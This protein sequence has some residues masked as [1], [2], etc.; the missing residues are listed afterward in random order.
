MDFTFAY[1][2]TRVIGLEGIGLYGDF[3]LRAEGAYFLTGDGEGNDPLVRNPYFQ[4]VAQL[5]WNAP[6]RTM[7]ILQYLGMAPTLLD[8]RD[9]EDTEE[10]L[11]VGMGALFCGFAR[12]AVM[13]VVKKDI[14]DAPHQVEA[15]A[16]YDID[17]DGYMA[18]AIQ[19]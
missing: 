3:A 10:V 7:V 18:G 11:P 5:D 6:E 1:P 4:Y 2:R 9:E 13:A 14:G 17:K 8:D 16:L 12:S 19:Y 15:R